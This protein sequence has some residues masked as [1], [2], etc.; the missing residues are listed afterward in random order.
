MM[1]MPLAMQIME[2]YNTLLSAYPLPTQMVT[3]SILAGVGDLIAQL[4][5]PQEPQQQSTSYDNN[6]NRLTLQLPSFLSSRHYRR[7]RFMRTTQKQVDLERSRRFMLKGLG[8]GIIWSFW[9]GIADD[10][11]NALLQQ[12]FANTNLMALLGGGTSSMATTSDAVMMAAQQAAVDTSNAPF[13]VEPAMAM[14]A[15]MA[16]ASTPALVTMGRTIV[17]ILLEQFFWVPLV[18][19]FWDIPVPTLLSKDIE[20]TSIPSQVQTKLPGLLVDNAKVW[21]FINILVYNAPVQYRVLIS[22]IADILW[23]S[24]L[25]RHVMTNDTEEVKDDGILLEGLASTLA[26]EQPATA[27]LGRRRPQQQQE[28]QLGKVS[29]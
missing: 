2:E 3:A 13:L 7:G 20:N 4:Q 14:E 15:P 12:E 22:S 19:T 5:L 17:A 18:Y 26:E 24:I 9:F 10:W 28:Q 21:T 23:Q 1:M 8:G 27:Q 25:S 6:D 16:P 29:V 11:S